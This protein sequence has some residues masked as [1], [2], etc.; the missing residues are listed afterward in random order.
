[1]LLRSTLLLGMAAVIAACGSSVSDSS[2]GAG[3]AGGT[4]TGTGATGTGATGTGSGTTGGGGQD[5]GACD[6]MT[7]CVLAEPGCCGGCGQ[8]TLD[9]VTPIAAAQA[10]AYFDATCPDP[11]NTPCPGCASFSNGNLYAYC[12]A[13]QCQEGDVSKDELGACSV[14]S[15]C[16]LRWGSGCCEGCGGTFEPGLGGDLIAISASKLPELAAKVCVGDVGCPECAPQ[17]PPNTFADC[18]DG[19]CVIVQAL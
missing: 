5:F 17:Y 11:E 2:S 1:M 18:L 10:Q 6:A 8:L 7:Q 19:R 4:G 12:E 9:G 14:P 3:G 13:G 16:V 15:D